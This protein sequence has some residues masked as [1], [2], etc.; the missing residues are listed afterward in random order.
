VNSAQRAFL[1]LHAAP[2]PPQH[3]KWHFAGTQLRATSEG[4]TRT[5]WRDDLDALVGAG[6][7]RKG[8]GCADYYVTDAGR[9]ALEREE[10]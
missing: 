10:A 8:A 1:R 2:T 6:L 9:V 4:G 7:L 3:W 5:I